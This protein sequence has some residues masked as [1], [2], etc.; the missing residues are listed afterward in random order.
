MSFVEGY[1]S[2]VGVESVNAMKVVLYELL[3]K[4]YETE[5]EHDFACRLAAAVA[6]YLFCNE[7]TAEEFQSFAAKNKALIESK[8]K[9]LSSEDSICKALTCSID[10]FCYGKYVDSGRKIGLLM[11]PFLAFTRGLQQVIEGKEP[12]DFLDSFYPK[13]GHEN[14]K[15]LLNLWR[16]GLYRPL[17]HT[18]D[19]KRMME[20]IA[21]FGRSVGSLLM[22]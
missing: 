12:V 15:P 20:E 7:P 6:N 5:Y 2:K 19:S 10:N 13:V 18:P 14:V 17:P 16:L 4:R 3:Q 11:H 21:R 22:K 8:A 9:Q 1:I